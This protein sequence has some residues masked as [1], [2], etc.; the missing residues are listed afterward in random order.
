MPVALQSAPDPG[1][2]DSTRRRVTQRLMP[3]LFLLYVIAYIDRINVSFAGL[4]MTGELHFSDAVFGLGSGIF[5]AGY[6]VLGIPGAILV[7]KWSARKMMATTMM[8]WGVV[9]AITGLIHTATEFYIMRF[10]LGVTEAGFFPGV[11]TYL[12][13]WHRIED[14]GKAVAMF[15]AAI[16][17][18]QVIAAPISAVLLKVHWLNLSGWRWLLIL[19]G[20]PAVICGIITLY[21]LT[22]RPA[23]AHWLTTAQRKWLID[24][25]EREHASKGA[26]ARMPIMKALRHPDIL[27]LS[28]VY[29]A[30]TIATYGLT[31]FL[32]KILQRL[33]GLTAVET[34]LLSAIPSLVA[35]PAMLIFGW[36]SDKTGERR[37]HAAIPRTAAAVALAISTVL[38]ANVPGALAMF[39]IAAAGNVAAYP[40]IWA[41]PS[42]LLGAAGAAASIGLI[43]SFGNLGGFVGPY[44]IG[45]FS[46]RTGTYAGG[47]WS[48]AI[49]SLASAILVLLVRHVPRR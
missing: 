44:V 32:P 14:R 20:V 28:A 16:P 15:M 48:M 2:A 30:G 49:A 8:V 11:I 29:F 25:L 6:L 31:L 27:L 46:S 10:V 7:E 1:V 9:A 43:N 3:F 37:W 39:A 33:S 18:S 19:E 36:H 13:H 41:M 26:H 40:A 24:G 4:Q 5:F 21:F 23:Q 47:L 45:W 22:D 38:T 34:A 35:V 17:L 42:T 12:S